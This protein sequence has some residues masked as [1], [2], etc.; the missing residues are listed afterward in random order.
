MEMLPKALFRVSD[1]NIIDHFLTLLV[2]GVLL[3]MVRIRNGNIAMC[4]GIHAGIV[5][6]MKVTGRFSDY[7]PGSQFDFLVNRYDHLLGYLSLAWLLVLATVYW[8]KFLFTR[9]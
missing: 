2:L 1:P 6:T 7:T 4:I 3:S 8:R 9:M 5:M